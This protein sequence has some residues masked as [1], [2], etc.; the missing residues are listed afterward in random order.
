MGGAVGGVVGV[1]SFHS[2]KIAVVLEERMYQSQCPRTL[3][4]VTPPGRVRGWA[5]CKSEIANISPLAAELSSRH[6][7]RKYFALSTKIFP[8]FLS[9][10]SPG[11]QPAQCGQCTMEK[12]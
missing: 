1:E 6:T 8:S 12:R 7:P 3:S 5:A 9:A 2:S 10:V 4:A 11:H